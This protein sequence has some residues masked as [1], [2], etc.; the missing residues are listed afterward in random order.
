MLVYQR[1]C[2]ITSSY[3]EVTERNSDMDGAGWINGS[4]AT[5]RGELCNRLG[6]LMGALLGGSSHESQVG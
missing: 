2:S 6:P 1:V 5:P 3:F 4:L